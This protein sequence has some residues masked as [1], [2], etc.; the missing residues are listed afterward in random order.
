[1][2]QTFHDCYFFFGLQIPSYQVGSSR[3]YANVKSKIDNSDPNPAHKLKHRVEEL[4][5][6]SIDSKKGREINPRFSR[7]KFANTRP[8][9]GRRG[10]IDYNDQ[11]PHTSV[12]RSRSHSAEYRMQR[13]AS[14][15]TPFVAQ[16]RLKL[17]ST[18]PLRRE[19]ASKMSTVVEIEREPLP[20]MFGVD[21]IDEEDETEVGGAHV[22]SELS[23]TRNLT[24]S[25]AFMEDEEE[26]DDDDDDDSTTKVGIYDMEVTSNETETTV[27]LKHLLA[28]AEKRNSSDLVIVEE[29]ELEEEEYYESQ[30]TPI[31][32]CSGSGGKFFTLPHPIPRLFVTCEGEGLVETVV[33]HTRDYNTAVSMSPPR[34]S[35]LTIKDCNGVPSTRL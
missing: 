14:V 4:T 8:T 1:M 28:L 12:N 10:T 23:H 11:F 19:L 6:L 35:P 27:V 3:R 13:S 2:Q 17:A 31:S 25:E 34:A 18:F 20:M 16:P 22:A 5:D 30:D 32:T 21:S 29:D 15:D 33:E 26:C 24:H 9:F 7:Q